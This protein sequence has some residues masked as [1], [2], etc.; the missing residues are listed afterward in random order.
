MIRRDDFDIR[1]RTESVGT[2]VRV[3]HIPTGNQ[4]IRLV[5]HSERTGRVRDAL[6]AELQGK[7]F[8]PNDIRVDIGCSSGGDFIRVTHIPSGIQRTALRRERSETDLLDEVLGELYGDP[9][10]FRQ[11]QEATPMTDSDGNN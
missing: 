6:I 11:I 7:L 8:D 1:I 10:K 3:T 5:A 2:V 9:D 4:R